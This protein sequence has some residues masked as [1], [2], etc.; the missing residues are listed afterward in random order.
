MAARDQIRAQIF[1]ADDL[2][3]KKITVPEWNGIEIVLV[4]VHGER[5]ARW[6]KQHALN[7]D[8]SSPERMAYTIAL[9][10]EDTSGA[11]IFGDED[12]AA[13][14]QKSTHVLKRIYDEVIELSTVS[15]AD[16]EDAAGESDAGRS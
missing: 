9:A 16:V 15:D 2:R 5:R 8:A 12:L 6:E 14:S 1:G 10:A 13:L 4:E 11:L 3:R 7:R